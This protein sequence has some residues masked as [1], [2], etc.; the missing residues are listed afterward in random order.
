MPPEH[1]EVIGEEMVEALQLRRDRLPRAAEELYRVVFWYPDIHGTDAGEELEVTRGAGQVT[2]KIEAPDASTR[3]RRVFTPSETEE[4]RIYLQGGDDRVVLRGGGEDDILVRIVGGGGRD[5]FHD[6][7]WMPQPRVILYDGG[8]RTRFPVTGGVRIERSDPDRPWSWFGLDRDLDWGTLTIPQ[9]TAS[10]DADRGLVLVPG[11]KHDRYGFGKLPYSVRLQAHGG[12]AF[13]LDEP[14]FDVRYLAREALGG[15]DVRA[16]FRWSGIEII[17]FYGLG[18]ETSTDQPVAFH[19]VAHKRVTATVAAGMGDGERRYFEIGP[20]FTYTSTDT[21]TVASF[22]GQT[23]PY[24]SGKFT[25]AGARAGFGI[26]TRDR[27]GTPTRGLRVAAGASAFPAIFD[28]TEAFGEL[29]AELAA[30]GSPL[31]E[32]VVLAGRVGGK[33]VWGRFPFSE[34]AFLG[35]PASVRS[36]RHQRYAGDAMALGSAEIRLEVGRIKFP[37]PSDVGVYGLADAGR[38]FVD[39]ETSDTWHTAA[40]GGLWFALINRSNVVR[41]SVARGDGRTAVH[42]GVGFAF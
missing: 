41:I 36:I 4:I 35:G 2:V 21:A 6:E 20:T 22:I 24:G 23:D 10:Y 42:A 14:I 13:G 32:A 30:Y 34:A 3:F 25:H 17:N 37:V 26:D 7:S 19:R 27:L 8:D 11:L 39:G 29:H 18:N 28:A 31:G 33:R 38:V 15:G 16:R 9:P 5:S 1:V 12:W 40:G